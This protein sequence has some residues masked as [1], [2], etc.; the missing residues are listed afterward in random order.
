[1]PN[2]AAFEPR[3][4]MAFRGF[5]TCSVDMSE[6]I[7]VMSLRTQLIRRSKEEMTERLGVFVN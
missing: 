2:F 3:F 5:L 6:A 4:T 7:S 1:M